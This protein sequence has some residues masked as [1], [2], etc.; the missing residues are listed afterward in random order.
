MKTTRFASV[1]CAVLGGVIGCILSAYAEEVWKP[2]SNQGPAISNTKTANVFHNPLGLGQDPSIKYYNGQYVY[3]EIDRGHSLYLYVSPHF[4]DILTTP[5]HVV[6]TDP[7]MQTS[8]APEIFLLTD[9][10]DGKKHWFIYAANS[11]HGEIRVYQSAT[12][13]PLSNYTCRGKLTGGY[14]ANILELP[15]GKLYLLKNGIHI[16]ALANPYTVEGKEVSITPKPLL[17][18]ETGLQEAPCSF[19]HNGVVSVVYSTH[20]WASPE[21]REGILTAKADSDLLSPDSWTKGPGP[22]FQ[23]NAANGVYGPGSICQFLSPDGTQ[24]W[25]AYGGFPEPGGSGTRYVWA[26]PIMGWDADNTPN[27]GVPLSPDT[28]V[29]VPSGEKPAS[30]TNRSP[31]ASSVVAYWQF[32]DAKNLGT[33]GGGRGN[34]LVARSGTP[35]FSS[36]GKF[37]GALYLDG[38]TTLRAD[39]GFSAERKDASGVILGLPFK[40][41][42]YTI[43]VWAK[44][45]KDCPRNGGFLGW[46][47]GKNASNNLRLNGPNSVTHYWIDNDFTVGRLATNPLD[48]DW[49]AL[50]VTWDGTTQTLYVDGTKAGERKP[51]IPP[52]ITWSNFIVGK[53]ILDVPF[54]GWMDNLLIANVAL[55]PA[56]IVDYQNG[57]APTG[58]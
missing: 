45:D 24:T 21:Y 30:A 29:P 33:D 4:G 25:I 46:G 16:V 10:A 47:S 32:E 7:D 41:N 23:A 35:V 3:A 27:L 40:A 1:A 11:G 2:A 58:L 37:G 36:A 20:Y 28:A 8:E 53:T 42:P 9:P 54:K 49:H 13:D 39:N 18:W 56:Q 43:A 55:A 5:K 34:R 48:G 6:Y 50:V 38:Q 31:L 14:D 52:A 26:Q 17:P 12:D 51:E 44:A 22:V 15:N 57:H 19:V